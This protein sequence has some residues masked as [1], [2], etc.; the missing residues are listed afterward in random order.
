MFLL[1]LKAISV[2]TIHVTGAERGHLL[3]LLLSML[4]SRIYRALLNACS[5]GNQRGDNCEG[6]GSGNFLE[7]MVT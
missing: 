4:I 3:A 2:A 1:S 6:T 5:A 7:G